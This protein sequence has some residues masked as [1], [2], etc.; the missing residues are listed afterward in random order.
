MFHN[1]L[2]A[3]NLFELLLYSSKLGRFEQWFDCFSI[4]FGVSPSTLKD[5]YENLKEMVQIK[6]EEKNY[7]TLGE[8][9][10]SFVW[11]EEI[12]SKT[13]R[14]GNYYKSIT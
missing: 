14:K 8:A 12:N 7:E 5:E 6:I 3:S 13:S 4:L 1:S 11:I 9:H 2:K 10:G